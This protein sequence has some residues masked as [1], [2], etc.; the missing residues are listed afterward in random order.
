MH[1]HK[2]SIS[3]LFLLIIAGAADRAFAANITS[4]SPLPTATVGIPYS[5]AFNGGGRPPHTWSATGLPSWLALDPATGVLTGTPLVAGTYTFTVTQTDGNNQTASA[6]FDLPVIAA[7]S[8]IGTSTGG[9]SFNIIDPSTTPGPITNNSV[10]QQVLFQCA[11]TV[12]YSIA[13]N[14]ASPSLTSG[15]DAIPFTL[16][17]AAAGQ[18]VTDTTQIPLLT[19]GSSMLIANYQNAPAGAYTSGNILVTISWTGSSTGSITATVT[20]SGTVINT[21]AVAQSPG[22]LI[23]T[24]DPSVAGVTTATISPDMQLKCTKNDS[25]SITAASSCGG[26]DSAYPACGGNKI[27]YTFNYLTG[28]TGQGFGGAGIPLNIGGTATSANY[29]NA[30]VGTYGDLQTLTITY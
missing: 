10:T 12:T 30:P 20:A 7:C 3:L 11:T 17:V 1:L 14:P 5:F 21:C 15:A 13:T 16:G 8:F 18:N 28:I 19:T 2:Y 4:K 6:S 23:F 29:E 24:I 9:I 27:L 26:L 22:T 25:V